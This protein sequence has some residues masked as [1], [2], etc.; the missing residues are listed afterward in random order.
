MLEEITERTLV[1]ET[2]KEL[3]EKMRKE[4]GEFD[5]ESRK[6]DE[7]RLLTQ[8]SRTYNKYVQVFKKTARRSRYK[9]RILVEEFKRELNKVIRRRLIEAELLPSTITE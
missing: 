7:L 8:G 9:K 3:F 2:I 1:V 6:V 5:E 4:F